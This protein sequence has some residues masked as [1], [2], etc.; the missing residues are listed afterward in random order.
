MN[1]ENNLKL[2]LSSI[3]FFEIGDDND[4]LV[5]NVEGYNLASP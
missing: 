3:F 5:R 2:Q 1:C 4:T